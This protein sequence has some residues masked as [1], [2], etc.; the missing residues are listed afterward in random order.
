MVGGWSCQRPTIHHDTPI[1]ISQAF[2]F[3]PAQRSESWWKQFEIFASCSALS[4][5]PPAAA[6]STTSP[7]LWMVFFTLLSPSPTL[8]SSL[9]SSSPLRLRRDHH[10]HYHG[11]APHHHTPHDND[12]DDDKRGCTRLKTNDSRQEN[13]NVQWAICTSHFLSSEDDARDGDGQFAWGLQGESEAR[14]SNIPESEIVEDYSW[15]GGFDLYFER[16]DSKYCDIVDK[17]LNVECYVIFKKNL[18]RLSI[19]TP[20]RLFMNSGAGLLMGSKVGGFI[21]WHFTRSGKWNVVSPQVE[22]LRSRKMER[23][24]GCH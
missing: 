21:I 11:R 3:S 5:H 24:A 23:S 16:C 15:Q 8:P 12:D 19:A 7:N 9:P 10:R 6:L 22:S 13:E 20:A 4:S 2:T 17:P 18:A 14:W 1:P